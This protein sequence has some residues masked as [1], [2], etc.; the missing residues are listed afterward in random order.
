LASTPDTATALL[1][2]GVLIGGVLVAQALAARRLARREIPLALRERV[3]LSNRL[4][5]WLLT[6]AVA[7]LSAGLVLA[8]R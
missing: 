3:A 7:M 6:A 2:A 8:L 1:Q 5:P 4:R